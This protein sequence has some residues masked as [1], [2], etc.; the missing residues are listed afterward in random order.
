[1]EQASLEEVHRQPALIVKTDRRLPWVAA[2]VVLVA[3]LIGC[4]QSQSLQEEQLE[5]AK[6]EAAAGKQLPLPSSPTMVASFALLGINELV[7]ESHAAIIG[8]V[9]AI[10]QPRWNSKTGDPWAGDREPAR[11]RVTPWRYRDATIKVVQEIYAS[12]EW[13]VAVDQ[14]ITIRLFGDGINTG[15]DL[16][17]ATPGMRSNTVSG[18]IESDSDGL[19][20]IARGAWIGEDG[21]TEII[22]LANHFQGNWMIDNGKAISAEPRR[23][24]PVNALVEKRQRERAAGRTGSK[25]G[26]YNPIGE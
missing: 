7:H 3:F 21:E 12:S 24:I 10:T 6:E 14:E 9:T 8:R 26:V 25:E 23:E 5:A 17:S 22:R 20:V 16:E 18:P 2:C 11:A 13:P 4:G 15:S 19:W 1:M